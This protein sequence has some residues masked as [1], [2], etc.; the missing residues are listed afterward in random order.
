MFLLGTA[1]MRFLEA[2]VA[3]DEVVAF[4]S[5]FANK[6][7][8][9]IRRY[10]GSM[11]FLCSSQPLWQ[12]SAPCQLVQELDS[13]TD[14]SIISLQKS[15]GSLHVMPRKEIKRKGNASWTKNDSFTRLKVNETSWM[16]NNYMQENQVCLSLPRQVSSL[17]KTDRCVYKDWTVPSLCPQVLF[18]T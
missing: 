14:D 4:W 16:E 18:I 15:F 7:A 9:Q 3:F 2:G 11:K 8:K 12:R 10:W 17:T 1:S 5:R 6:K 13:E